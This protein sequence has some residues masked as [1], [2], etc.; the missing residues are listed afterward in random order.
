MINIADNARTVNSEVSSKI[1]TGTCAWSYDEWR[2]IFYPEQ[3]PA[4]QRLEFYARHFNSVEIDSTF[5]NTPG[6]HVTGQ[7][8]DATPNDFVFAP[9]IS[10]E[11]SHERKLRN[12]Q[13]L[14]EAF[15]S[16]MA[17]LH[18]KL[19]CVLVQLPPSF[20][21]RHDEH[22]LR[23]FILALPRDFRFALEF[24]DPGWHLPRVVH[25]LEEH[26]L[27][28]VWNDV[29][30]FE[31]AGE[32]AFDFFPR[33]TDFLYVRLLGDFESTDVGGRRPQPDTLLWPRDASLESWALKIKQHLEESTQVLIY[34]TN[35]FEG[36]A[37][38]TVQRMASHFGVSIS[39][40]TA[41]ELQG[42][43]VEE[44]RQLDLL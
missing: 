2:G 15:L 32:A 19:A 14:L 18:H 20:T 34:S 23:E 7:W 21:P 25:L 28:W 13:E 35:Q 8:L 16:S 39:L 31:K 30:P 12:C 22:A 36:F 10:R 17:P 3:L 37:P 29:T 40:P 1:K 41:D 44:K 33:T 42:R 26:G 6:P 5:Y 38:R 11:I 43:S 4:N 27:C 24:R 9:K